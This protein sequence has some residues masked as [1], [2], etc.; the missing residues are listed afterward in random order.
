MCNLVQ[1]FQLTEAQY[2]TLLAMSSTPP[3]P[4]INFS[5]LNLNCLYQPTITT[6]N[7]PTG[8]TYIPDPTGVTT[9]KCSNGCPPNNNKVGVNTD[10]SPVC[11]ICFNTPCPPPV[12][13]CTT[14][15]NPVPSPVTLVGIL[16]L[17]I[18]K[19]CNC[20]S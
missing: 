18:N 16:Q 3:T 1:Q 15:S 20:C 9:G 19:L 2:Q 4:P 14:S 13:I 12:P 7:C 8:W 5:G 6:C 17:I 11:E 10:G